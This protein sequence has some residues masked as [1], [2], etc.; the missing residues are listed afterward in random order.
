[1]M[2]CFAAVLSLSFVVGCGDD[3]SPPANPGGG[4]VTTSAFTGWLANSVE[5][6]SLAIT[7]N[8]A[9]LAGRIGVPNAPQAAVTAS[10]TLT[11]SG[12]APITLTGTFDDETGDVALA[13]TIGLGYALAGFYVP[14]P[15]SNIFGSYTGPNGSGSFDCLS[16]GSSSATVM[17][18]I[19]TSGVLTDIDGNFLSGTFTFTIREGA[20]EG[21]VY[22]PGNT[23]PADA[24]TFT[25]SVSGTGTSRPVTATAE[26]PNV[27]RLAANG[28]LDTTTNEI[29]D[30]TYL[31]D[32]LTGGNPDDTGTWQSGLCD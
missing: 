9:G 22:V 4:G 23:P 2:L 21:V 12:A 27:Y 18:G 14:A 1:M 31:F 5:N 25:G 26:F 28:T 13:D 29:T 19:W 24:I 8:A 17:C 6:G 32:D 11:L 3:E 20:I 10:G 30:G 7:I 16:G 15:P